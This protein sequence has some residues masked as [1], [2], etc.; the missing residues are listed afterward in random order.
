M[1]KADLIYANLISKSQFVAQIHIHV[2]PMLIGREPH[3]KGVHN[4]TFFK[5]DIN[6]YGTGLYAVCL[7]ATE[8]TRLSEQQPT[9]PILQRTFQTDIN[10]D[11]I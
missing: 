5:A 4:A 11:R 2:Y 3:A 8:I 10:S 1:S 9:N 6:T 7:I